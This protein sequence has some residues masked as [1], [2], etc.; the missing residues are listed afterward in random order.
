MRRR[1]LSAL[2]AIAAVAGLL[3][4]PPATAVFITPPLPD[5][6]GQFAAAMANAIGGMKW[7][8]L[9][10]HVHT[11]HSHDAGF[12]HQQEKRPENHDTFV[13]DQ[14]GEAQRQMMNVA[15][16]TDHRTYDQAYDP[17]YRSD[18][19]LLLDGEEWGG[20][21]P[22]TAWGISEVLE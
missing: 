10:G 18:T 3:G 16:L 17:D 6:S 20:Y 22:A 14:L 19:L 11:D 15:T 21:P 13:S 9:D 8:G 2:I 1:S 5:P 7:Y 4:A 12:F